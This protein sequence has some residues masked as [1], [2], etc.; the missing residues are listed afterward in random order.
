[1][2]END[3][4]SWKTGLQ[5]MLDRDARAYFTSCN[6]SNA[7]QDLALVKEDVSNVR[8]EMMEK[9]LFRETYWKNEPPSVQRDAD[10]LFACNM[11]VVLVCGRCY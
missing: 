5:V 10:N 11:Y 9:N 7:V 3:T 4:Q 6:E 8:H 2:N 1:V